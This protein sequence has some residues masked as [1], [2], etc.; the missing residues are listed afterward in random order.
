MQIADAALSLKALHLAHQARVEAAGSM[1][2]QAFVY[3]DG[4]AL[5][6]A[7]MLIGEAPGEQE[8]IQRRPFVG[9]AGQILNHF[10]DVLALKREDI[11]ISNVVKQRPTRQSAAGRLVNRPPSPDEIALFAPWLMDEVAFIAPRL[12]V[13]LGNVP[14]QAFLGPYARIGDSHGQ[15]YRAAG[16][17]QLFALYHPAA[18]IYKPA[19]AEVYEADLLRLKAVLRQA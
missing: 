1:G 8:T 7:L 16:G 3:G 17:Q 12:L 13:T 10:L 14:L 11:Y 6:P 18:T 2:E 19:L 15:L 5:H 4:R 9:K